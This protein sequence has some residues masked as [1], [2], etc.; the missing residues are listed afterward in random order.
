MKSL[1]PEKQMNDALLTVVEMTRCCRAIHFMDDFHSAFLQPE[2]Y[3]IPA[4]FTSDHLKTN[5]LCNRI[6]AS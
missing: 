3:Y 6:A 5:S 2:N 4:S 1:E